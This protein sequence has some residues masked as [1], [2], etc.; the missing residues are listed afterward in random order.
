[1]EK[2]PKNSNLGKEHDLG[3]I[4]KEQR[5]G[6]ERVKI[7]QRPPGVPECPVLGWSKRVFGELN[8]STHCFKGSQTAHYV[9]EGE[10]FYSGNMNECMMK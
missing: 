4:I 10:G 1:M 2:N 6:Q 3:R 7:S 9:L 8:V 5:E